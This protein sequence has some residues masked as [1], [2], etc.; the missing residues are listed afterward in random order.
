MSAERWTLSAERWTLSAAL[1][2]GERSELIALVGGGGKTSL[3]FALAAELPGR[4]V[5]TTTTRIFAAQMKRAPAIVYAEELSPLSA[6]LD[7]HGRCLVVGRV[8]GDK[9]FGV[10]PEL[11]ARLLA[12]P[13]VD[14]VLVEA[15]GSR[16][17]PVKAPGDHEP[18][19]PPETTLLVPV[20][21]IDAL[22]GPLDQVA[23]RPERVR[24]ILDR[25]VAFGRELLTE[26]RLTPAG[27]ARLVVH[28]QG[29]AK[30]APSGA[31]LVP[32]LNKVETEAQL[33]V[34]RE[35]AA[36]ALS[37]PHV[38]RVVIGALHAGQP[39]LEVARRVAA[40]ILAAG[41][42]SRMGRN[43][44][45][46][47]WGETTVLGQTLV[48]LRTAATHSALL[49]TGYEPEPV[50]VLAAKAG[51]PVVH[52]PDYRSGMLS[53]VQAAARRLA[54]A[55]GAMLVMLGDHP[56]VEPATINQLLRAYAAGPQGLVAPVYR[57]TRGNPVLID[58]RYFPELLQLSPAD[59]PRTLLQR[60][61]ADVRLVEV[62]DEAILIDL[63]RPEDYE[64][65]RP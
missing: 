47:P 38:T 54:P 15:D 37:E 10:E 46:L 18:V 33:A 40:V 6:A 9:A 4:T 25:E 60:H 12:R 13:D 39:V 48:N 2:L 42:S 58:R 19:V 65:R 32:F 50:R 26:D 3:M 21:G 41:E 64:R 29:G 7:E 59:A 61:P 57:G 53:S 62:N 49:V 31:R 24:A 20:A 22:E 45:H 36:V 56:L 16:M 28:P 44:L 17:R 14:W 11:S 23:H 43:K 63:D 35:A 5:I 52:N 34:A 27:L 51:I 30:S 1:G 55:I 8:E